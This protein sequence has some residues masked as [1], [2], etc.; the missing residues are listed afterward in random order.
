MK[1]GQTVSSKKRTFIIAMI[2]LAAGVLTVS[3]F[4]QHQHEDIQSRYA[5]QKCADYGGTYDSFG[6]GSIKNIVDNSTEVL[7]A[8]VEDRDVL[9][10]SVYSDGPAPLIR[11]E[12]V[13]KGNIFKGEIIPICPGMGYME[14]P[15]GQHPT[16]LVFI[17]GKDGSIFVPS[18]GNF[19]VVPQ[20]QDGRFS[21][22]WVSGGPKAVTIPEL[23]K[24]VK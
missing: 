18:W 21:P 23:Q 2:L 17:E 20:S 3:L 4:W 22:K 11:V 1:I 16:V 5:A 12:Q 7:V 19:G 13:L 14:L 15:D 24:L 8:T 10:K 9:G 6:P